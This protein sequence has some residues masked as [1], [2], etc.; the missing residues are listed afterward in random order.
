MANIFQNVGEVTAKALPVLVNN[1]IMPSLV[2]RQYDREFGNKPRQIGDTLNIRLPTAYRATTDS[3]AFSAQGVQESVSPLIVDSQPHVDVALTSKEMALNVNDFMEQVMEP[4]SLALANY[5]DQQILS[6]YKVVPGFNGTLGTTPSGLSAFQSAY[7]KLANAP[8]PMDKAWNA[9]VDPFTQTGVIQGV[10]TF[11]NDPKQVSDQYVKNQMGKAA[12]LTWYMDQNVATHT[13]G[14][15]AANIGTAVTVNGAIS[16]GTASVVF[17]GWTSG[18]T[19]KA[20]DVLTFTG[21]YDVNFMSKGATAYE[22]PFV[23]VS[24]ATATG[25]G[26]MTVT[27]SPTPQFSGAFKNAY[28]ASGTIPTNT[29]L[30]AVNGK[31]GANVTAVNA[32]QSLV[33]HP[34]AF[35][36]AF[37]RLPDYQGG[38]RSEQLTDKKTGISMRVSFSADLFTDKNLMRLDVLF[39]KSAPRP[40]LAQR[41]T[42]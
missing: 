23:V 25:G 31:T 36:V 40:E 2:N 17:A 35:T 28:S 42:S 33:F 12:G 5:I 19:L 22:K 39:G 11:F 4:A 41:V 18:D 34:D 15:Y 27:I 21:V 9:V 29:V 7:S 38:A 6:L 13:T 37:C 30:K 10:Q 24:D 14:A 16:S 32:N 8:A 26:A 3:V 20:G 1:T